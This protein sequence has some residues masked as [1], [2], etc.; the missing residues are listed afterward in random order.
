MKLA[1]LVKTEKS[2][3]VVDMNDKHL[4]TFWFPKGDFIYLLQNFKED[5][6]LT[7]VNELEITST[8]FN[9]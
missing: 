1:K 6:A 8:T 2:I 9:F 4:H 5:N 7:I 3:Q